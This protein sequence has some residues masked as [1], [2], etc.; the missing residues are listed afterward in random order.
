MKTLQEQGYEVD[1]RQIRYGQSWEDGDVLT[2]ALKVQTGDHCLAIASGGEN[3][4]GLLLGSPGR[5]IALDRN[6]A[7]ISLVAAKV[8]AFRCLDH[9][10][11]LKLLGS[12]PAAGKER[13]GLYAR[14]RAAMPA[15]ARQHWDRHPDLIAAGLN[16]SGRFERYF[17]LFQR[18]VLPRVHGLE[19]IRAVLEPRTP[20]ARRAFYRE[21][22]DT[23]AW[24]RMFRVFF[25]RGVMGALGRDR[26]HF[27]HVHGK[28]SDRLLERTE[29]ALVELDPSA[30]PYLR[31]ILTGHHGEVLPFA[32]RP[33]NFEAIR[34][35]LDRLELHCATV[36]AWLER[37]GSGWADR[38]YLSNLFEYLDEQESH[39]LLERILH[40][41]HSG[42]RLVYWNLLVPRRRPDWMD[43]RIESLDEL[44]D[45]LFRKDRAFFYSALVVEQAR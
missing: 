37:E 40:A 14:C 33:E 28:V 20:E 15:R 38:F 10:E 32:L 2:Q 3:A 24:R 11:M 31:W 30:N 6:P 43:P 7:Q 36:E 1:L 5:V 8:A 12:S 35:N 23:A 4:L 16:A 25:S 21:V 29:H 27:Q 34:A 39:R 41:S 13:L 17:R 45:T 42:A 44:A 18:W 19:T 26:S 9:P 22:W